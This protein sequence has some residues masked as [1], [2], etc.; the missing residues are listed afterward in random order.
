[1]SLVSL[2]QSNI[3]RMRSELSR[4]QKNDA[5]EIKK[6]ADLGK[7]IA[8]LAS[9]SAKASSESSA[10]NYNRQAESKSRDLERVRDSRVRLAKQL[11]DK[12]GALVKEEEKLR[13]AEG[14][15]RKKQEQEAE[16]ERKKAVDKARIDQQRRDREQRAT[17]ARREESDAAR[18]SELASV[19]ARTT[20]LEERLLAADLRKAPEEV[21]VL[22][23]AATPEDQTQ[24]RI[25]KETREIQKRVRASEH[26][27]AIDFQWRLARQ[28]T[29]LI[30]DLSEVAPHILHFSG[31][32]SNSALAFEGAGGESAFMTND[33]L[34][35][36][37][38]ASSNRIRLIVFNS[39]DSADQ[40]QLAVNHV[41]LAIG[42]DE[43]IEDE[44][45]KTFA[46]Q[47]YASLGF[48][49]SVQQAFDEAK[50]QVEL[51]AGAGSEIPKLFAADGI[52]PKTVALINPKEA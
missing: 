43:S 6:E 30:Q 33:Q 11:A 37:L 44:A 22:F 15:E 26:R 49:H 36:L 48:G 5:A 40:A 41:D 23:L 51:D 14:Q 17:D 32:G 4:L 47:F 25:S 21:T 9:Q 12:Q 16:R 10:A 45:A 42:M 1:M 27:D 31:H 2:Y 38:A 8:R 34:D 39:C 46:G 35:S 3:K 52:D 24:L 50:L 29:D 13:A 20:E 18:D 7:A 19:R 28:L